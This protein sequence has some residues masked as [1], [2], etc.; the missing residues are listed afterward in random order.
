MFDSYDLLRRSM[1]EAATAARKFSA[2]VMSHFSEKNK[3]KRIVRWPMVPMTLRCASSQS[4][5][6]PWPSCTLTPP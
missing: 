6:S 5:S 4:I 1:T 3:N 2:L